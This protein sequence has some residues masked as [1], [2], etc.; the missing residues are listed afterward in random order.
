MRRT[1]WWTAVTLAMAAIG[2][3]LA[4]GLNGLQNNTIQLAVARGEIAALSDAVNQANGRLAAQGSAPVTVPPVTTATGQVQGPQGPVGPRGFTGF[5]GA[6]G[7]PGVPG[8]PGLPG[9][10]GTGGKG[11]TDGNAGPAGSAGA[12]GTNG[13]TGPDGAPGVAGPAGVVGVAGPAGVAGAAGRGV[14]SI[15]CIDAPVTVPPTVPASSWLITYTDA[16]TTTTPGP[17]RVGG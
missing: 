5:T 7:V 16:T 4:L 12:P 13:T 17:C 10:P 8:V 2:V 15:D 14:V 1:I 9:D 3:G 11:G 6:Q